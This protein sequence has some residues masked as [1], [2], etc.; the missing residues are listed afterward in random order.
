MKGNDWSLILIYLCWMIEFCL[1]DNLLSC[2]IISEPP[3]MS[4][5]DCKALPF[6]LPNALP[7]LL[8][9]ALPFL[10]SILLFILLSFLLSILLSSLLPLLYN[11]PN[12]YYC[13]DNPLLF[14][15]N[16]L[17]SEFLDY[18]CPKWSS[19]LSFFDYNCPK[20]SSSLSFF[21]YNCPKWSS[22]LSFLDY[23]CPKWSASFSILLLFRMS[24]E[25]R[26]SLGFSL[27]LLSLSAN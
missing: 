8:P 6:L 14:C 23:K 4:L 10:L 15:L 21:Y 27:E 20:W 19:S 3:E 2:C 12:I 7:F 1:L 18:N 24:P 9:N 22:L 26:L 16:A 13:F 17:D 11:T 25:L 5:F